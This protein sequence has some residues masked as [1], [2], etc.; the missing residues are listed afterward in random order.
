MS[1]MSAKDIKVD[2]LLIAYSTT[3]KEGTAF[4]TV[5]KK[6]TNG[7]VEVINIIQGQEATD[8]YNKLSERIFEE[9]K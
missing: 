1:S 2:T 4:L 9:A 7:S 3:E 8:I 6:R 5:G